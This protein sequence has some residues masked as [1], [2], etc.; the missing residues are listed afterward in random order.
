M[1]VAGA[2]RARSAGGMACHSSRVIHQRCAV[3]ILAKDNG[4]SSFLGIGAREHRAP[5]P[6]RVNNY[7][8]ICFAIK[9]WILL[10]CAANPP[11]VL[12]WRISAPSFDLKLCGAGQK[13][14]S[15]A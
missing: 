1:M 13:H 8:F 3:S 5:M 15:P 2:R 10:P 7:F 12:N 11:A 14:T 4:L 6:G 9:S